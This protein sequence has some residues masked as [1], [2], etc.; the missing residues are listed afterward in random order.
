MPSDFLL[1]NMGRVEKVSTDARDR[2]QQLEA[3]RSAARDA[4][5][6]TADRQA[7]QYDKHRRAYVFREGDSVLLNPF[8]L[9][10][11]EKKG[12]GKKLMPRY[13]GPF[14]VLEVVSPTAYWIRL[15]DAYG[16]HNVINVEHLKPYHGTTASDRPHIPNPRDMV[17]SSKEY[18]VD[19]IVA[20]QR[21]KGQLYYRIRWTGYDIENDTW[22]TAYDLRNAPEILQQWRSSRSSARSL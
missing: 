7:F 6:R 16:M 13:L 15:P 9:E 20:E 3:H 19:R 1:E 22:Q 17:P 4:I 10:L 12:L 2:I 11:V 18:N 8:S 5:K 14:E 21:R